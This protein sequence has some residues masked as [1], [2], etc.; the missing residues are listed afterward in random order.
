MKQL[1]YKDVEDLCLTLSELYDMF[2]ET[3]EFLDITIV[4]KY[5][6]AKQII[7]EFIYYDFTLYDIEL[8]SPDLGS[9]DCEYYISLMSNKEIYCKKAIGKDGSYLVDESSIAFIHEDCNSKILSSVRSNFK[10]MVFT[11]SNE[12]EED[13]EFCNYCDGHKKCNCDGH[14][15]NT[16]DNIEYCSL[17]DH[18]LFDEYE[19][20]NTKWFSF[21]KNEDGKSIDV[22]LH[23]TDN[24]G[25]KELGCILDKLSY[26]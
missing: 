4:A 24:V 22:S 2:C 5:D 26:L 10:P 1:F 14:D 20:N 9:Y 3:H 8:E 12:C 18:D 11:L 25:K 19:D 23:L 7:S 15:L 16:N 13:M 6:I 21:H 17:C